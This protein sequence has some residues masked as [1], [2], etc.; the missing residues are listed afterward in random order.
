MSRA[1][2]ICNAVAGAKGWVTFD[3]ICSAVLKRAEKNKR[4]LVSAQLGQL[5]ESGKLKRRG[6]RLAF[7]YSA[8]KTTLLDLR[9]VTAN[10]KPRDKTRARAETRTH[11]RPKHAATPKPA[12]KPQ[13]TPQA[14]Q[15]MTIVKPAMPAPGAP[16]KAPRETIEQFLARGGRIQYLKHG[17]SSETLA[18]DAR[19]LNR[20][21]KESLGITD[22]EPITD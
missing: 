1:L 18:M 22:P 11:T 20:R 4:S 5:V 21:R 16:A 10:G 2:A 8:T 3:A 17:E 9:K 13:A 12:P 15:K 14:H 7:E 6:V 19:A